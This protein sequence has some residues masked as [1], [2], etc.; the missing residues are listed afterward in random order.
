MRWLYKWAEAAIPMQKDVSGDLSENVNVDT[1][2]LAG[3]VPRLVRHWWFVDLMSFVILVTLM[4]VD[5]LKWFGVLGQFPI[6]LEILLKGLL[7]S[8]SCIWVGNL[9]G[10]RPPFRES[11]HDFRDRLQLIWKHPWKN[12]K[13]LLKTD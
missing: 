6:L 13:L 9:L 12:R 5:T 3:C 2:A 10:I 7:Y 1:P 11:C 8:C 4:V